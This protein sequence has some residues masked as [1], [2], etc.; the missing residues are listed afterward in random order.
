VTIKVKGDRHWVVVSDGA[1]PTE[2]IYFL[3]SAALALRS[4]L[5]VRCS[6]LNTRRWYL[7]KQA[8]LLRLGG[9]NLIIC[10]SLP[11]PWLCFLEQYRR[12]FGSII[13]LI[14]DDL[15]AAIDADAL[16]E[17]YRLRLSRIVDEQQWR[18]LALADEVV[19]SSEYLAEQLRPRHAS[20]SVLNPPL[21]VPLPSLD[22]F[23]TDPFCI[24]YHG[25]RAHLQDLEFVTPVLEKIHQRYDR[26]WIELM[27]GKYVPDV[28]R[29]LDR[30]TTPAPLSWSKFRSYQQ[31]R[32]IHIG[33]APLLDTPFNRGKSHIKFLD[34]AAMGGVGIYSDRSPYSELVEQGVDGLLVGD[35]L[36]DWYQGICYLIDNPEDAKRMAEAAAEKALRIGSLDTAK[37]FWQSRSAVR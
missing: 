12:Y 32:R 5:G 22:H 25:T 11:M 9:A 17:A 15:V 28:L 13:Y 3:L 18:I 20:V 36:D 34:I 21:I 14:D 4:Q 30:V 26:V 31:Q 7:P 6:R 19:A 8:A 10:R 35:R 16:P 1:Q 2:D 29:S 23:E 24:G 27:L 33:L 37:R